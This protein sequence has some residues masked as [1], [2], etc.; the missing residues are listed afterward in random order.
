MINLK[1]SNM[2]SV[3]E[4]N[5]SKIL[6]TLFL[7]APISRIDIANITSLTPP[8]IT[9]NIASL[10]ELGLVEEIYDNSQKTEAAIGRKPILLDLI[11]DSFFA[12]GVDWG[13]NG[14]ICCLTDLRGN[15]ITKKENKI[16]NWEEENTV[17]ETSALIESI[18]TETKTPKEK[19]LGVGV[20]IPG[21]VETETGFVRYSPTHNWKNISIGKSLEES[22]GLSV[23]IENNVRVMSIGEMLF[24]SKAERTGGNYL[25]VYIGQGIACA[26]VNNNELLRG[27]IFGAGE[28]GHTI[29]SLNGPKCRCGKR[30]CLEAISSE[31]AIKKNV[32]N[33]LKGDF[34]TMLKKVV[35]VPEKPEMEEILYAYECGDITTIDLIN[36]SV[37]HLGA[38]VSNVIN[39]VN[40]KMVIF[41]GR[42]FNNK[43]LR[44]DI[45]ENI[46]KNTFALMEYETDFKFKKYNRDF[47]A[48]G[49]AAFAIKRFL[50]K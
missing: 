25:Y 31:Y 14:I 3:K 34:D 8:T 5:K 13:P 20:G 28:L 35:K 16:E 11:P 9:S 42:I 32:S 19:I 36:N 15:V 44:E 41:D 48:I 1:G 39:L 22:T 23:A 40:P 21:F 33:I 4:V 7:H 30:G 45:L 50:I 18:M 29:V 47:S 2:V 46:K 24:S 17:A 26:I 43:T 6:Q 12:V 10:I 49:G 27:N 38:G 37:I